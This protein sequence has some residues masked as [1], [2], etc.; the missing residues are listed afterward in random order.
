MLSSSNAPS[1]KERN[2][3]SEDPFITFA[4]ETP[5]LFLPL[6]FFETFR[7]IEIA[8]EVFH[9]PTKIIIVVLEVVFVF[10]LVRAERSTQKR[11]GRIRGR[12]D[13]RRRR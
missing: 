2:V 4:I 10:V 13:F 9:R 5:L 7:E 1:R 11:R 3:A 8:A 6:L 12:G